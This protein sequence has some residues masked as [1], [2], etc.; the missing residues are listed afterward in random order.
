MGISMQGR[1][2]RPDLVEE[3]ARLR[4]AIPFGRDRYRLVSAVPPARRR[5]QD[6]DAG[7]PMFAKRWD[8]AGALDA[9]GTSGR[10]HDGY[11]DRNDPRD[12]P[13]T[14]LSTGRPVKRGRFPIE[15]DRQTRSQRLIGI[16]AGL[17]LVAVAV[18]MLGTFLPALAWAVVLAIATWPLFVIARGYSGPTA[19]AAALTLLIAV[20]V[21]APLVVAGF[22][23][24]H[25]ARGIAEWIMEARKNGFEPRN[26][27]RICRSSVARSP[28]G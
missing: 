21:L 23:T 26:G 20:A 7:I 28:I 24:A 12:R 9:A 16:A 4:A 18:W 1:S 15:P 11:A 6:G 19:A 3:F 13:A 2:I 10:S 5:L 27:F 8:A 25:E 17:G 22:E 14:L